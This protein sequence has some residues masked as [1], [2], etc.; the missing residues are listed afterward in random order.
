MKT[1]GII[2]SRRRN[3]AADYLLLRAK[4]REIF[5]VGDRLVSGGCP[6]GADAF[7]EN[8]AHKDGLT[9]IIHHAN[10]KKHPKYGGFLRNRKIAEDCDVLIALP[11]ADRKGGTEDTIVKVKRLRKPV[12]IVE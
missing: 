3:K 4:L 5:E 12:I 1:I 6:E 10:W 9:I 11:A 8:I 2:G 7:A